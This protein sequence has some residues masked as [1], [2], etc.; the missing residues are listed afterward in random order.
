VS[1]LYNH[2]EA[3]ERLGGDE[4]LFAS[5]ASLFVAESEG[6]CCALEAAMASADV[7]AVR[8]EAHTVKSMLATFSYEAG[9]ELAQ[10]LEHLAAA[11]SLEGADGLTA[12][13]VA[14]VRRL[15]AVLPKDAA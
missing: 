13:V 14:A 6:Y 4:A 10:R 8:R 9:R 11:G 5:V 1:E 12:E 3:V 15:V 2:A 7:V